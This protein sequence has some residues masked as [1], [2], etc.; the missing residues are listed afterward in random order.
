MHRT[1]Y[2]WKGLDEY[3]NTLANGVYLYR[4]VAKNT[5]GKAFESYDNSTS[6]YFK[7]GIGKLVI[8]R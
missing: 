7:K 2:V 1:D 4:V 8:I 6:D 5:D 3:G